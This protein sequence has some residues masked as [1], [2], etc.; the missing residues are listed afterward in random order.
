MVSSS[1]PE[2]R[3]EI[4]LVYDRECP[5]CN[6]YCQIVRIRES[7][8]ELR[9]VDAREDS[10]VLKEI[11]AAGLDIDQGMVL[12]MDEQLYY[13]A[14]AIHALALIG[15]RSGILSRFNHWIFRSKGRAA[16]LYPMLR[17]FRNLLLK[18]LG[19]TK[20]N[21]LGVDGNQRF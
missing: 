14:D 15:S 5:A 11:T 7:V 21:N 17:F 20:I 6:A 9:I 16:V 10:E 3:P 8:G 19:K 2:D 4:L 13:G 1:A 18:L 12:K